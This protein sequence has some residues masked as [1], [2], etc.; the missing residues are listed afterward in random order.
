MNQ[1]ELPFASE[2][3]LPE[4]FAAFVRFHRDNPVIYQKFVEFAFAGLHAGRP[5]F[6]ARMIGVRVRWYLK[7]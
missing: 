3:P 7:I 2:P 4:R 1:M 6:G 5:R